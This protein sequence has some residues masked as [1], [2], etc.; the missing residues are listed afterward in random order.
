M[1]K[2][3]VLEKQSQ[4]LKKI[5]DI[6]PASSSL[7]NELSEILETSTDS[8]YRRIRCE[9]LLSIDEIIKL[10]DHF[11][12]TFD[13]FSKNEN[14]IV[15]FTY[16]KIESTV[17]SFKEYL[18]KLL[19]DIE[20]INNSKEK[21][22][23]IASEDIPLFHHYNHPILASFKMFYWIHTILNAEE[24][25]FE[26]FDAE[27]LNNELITTGKQIAEAYSKIPSIEIWTETTIHS[28]IKQIEYFWESGKFKNKTDALK[29]CD[30]LRNEINIIQKQ[31]EKESKINSL[32]IENYSEKEKNY[33]LY[34]SDM[35]IT[36]NCVYVNVGSLKS[37]FLG[38]FTF[39]TMSTVNDTYCEET[40]NW[41]NTLIKKSS[42]ISG[43]SEKQ[44]YQVFKKY[45]KSIDELEEK[46]KN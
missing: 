18:K 26:K 2:T 19:I 46:I 9:T 24:L 15:T 38:H 34:F 33:S 6:I 25:E 30:E 31:A 13:A 40:L 11:N 45:M 29:V 12:I 8:A 27:N 23:I 20:T 22:I 3:N 44:R 42:L 10:C 39:S 7:V 28:T 21:Q 41:L 4:F 43:V 17:N 37:V 14:S 16:T 35:E 32:N 1:Q 5:E 36:N